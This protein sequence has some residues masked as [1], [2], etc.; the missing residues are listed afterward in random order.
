LKIIELEEENKKL[1]EKDKQSQAIIPLLL[2]KA[3][4]LEI[5]NEE[6]LLLE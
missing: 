4:Q 2:E 6:V 5:E 1:R 3:K